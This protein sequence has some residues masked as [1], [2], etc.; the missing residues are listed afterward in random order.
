MPK[1]SSLN[2]ILSYLTNKK[3]FRVSKN[4]FP[5][6]IFKKIENQID[7]HNEAQMKINDRSRNQNVIRINLQ[8]GANIKKN[9]SNANM[10]DKDQK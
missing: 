5:T 10:I 8:R 1:V 6:N 3:P 4:G 9:D 2:L 7:N